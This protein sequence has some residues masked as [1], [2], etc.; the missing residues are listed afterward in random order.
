MRTLGFLLGFMTILALAPPALAKVFARP[1]V[2]RPLR[3]RPLVINEAFIY[4][5]A[6]FVRAAA[7]G[8]LRPFGEAWDQV[9][10]RSG[11]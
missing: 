1:S 6:P 9:S 10:R 11:T 5:D 3:G 8:P 4:P 7:G 2:G